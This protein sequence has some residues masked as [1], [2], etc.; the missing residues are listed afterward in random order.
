MTLASSPA[1]LSA[2]HKLELTV[3]AACVLLVKLIVKLI[4]KLRVTGRLGLQVDSD[5]THKSKVNLK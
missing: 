5:V 2:E 3:T 1:G 4:G